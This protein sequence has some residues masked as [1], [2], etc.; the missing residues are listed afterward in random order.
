MKLVS[1]WCY[2]GS[3]PESYVMPPETRPGKS[4]VP[5]G[6]SIPVIDFQHQDRNEMVHQIIKAGEEYGFFQVINHG[7]CEDLM[8]ETMKV[9]E[10]FHAMPAME[11]EKECSKDPNGS[12]KLYT[13]SY[14]YPREDFHL[15]RDAVTHPCL[16][17]EECIQFWPENPTKYS[18]GK[19]KGAEHRVVTNSRNARTT[20]SYFVYPSDECIIEPAKALVNSCN[21]AIY[22]AFKYIDF[23]TAFILKA[24][25]TDETVKELI[26]L[27]YY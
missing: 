9:A 18:N 13:S 4:I 27:D 16:P 24:E 2:D 11:K 8:E 23:L 26:D 21:P 5:L 19:L 14:S 15:W 22:K 10:E 20:V 17:S 3:L 7:V 1:S 25:N 6:K 12:C